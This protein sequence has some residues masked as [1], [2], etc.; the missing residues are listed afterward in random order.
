MTYLVQFQI[1]PN[2]KNQILDK[3]EMRGPNRVPGVSFKQ[4]W[5]STKQDLI[6]VIGQADHEADLQKACSFIDEFG[7]YSY[8]EV[9]DLENY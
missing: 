2:T 6:Y 3:F 1:K 5:V 7:T 8:T 9:V 4:A